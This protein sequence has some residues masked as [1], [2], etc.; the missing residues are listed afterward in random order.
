[1]KKALRGLSGIQLFEIIKN[2]ETEYEV[3]A[4]S[5]RL[6]YAQTMTRDVQ[7][8]SDP[9]YADDEI[10][11]D[12]EVLEGEDMELTIPEVALDLLPIVEGGTYDAN[13]KEYSFG[14]N[15]G[16]NYAMTFKSKMKNGCY[17]MFRYYNVKFKK[18]K[19]DLQTLD[20]GTQIASVVITLTAYRRALIETGEAFPK[21]R[22][23]KDTTLETQ[24]KDLK[25]LN[26]VPKVS[27]V[28]TTP[29]DD[30]DGNGEG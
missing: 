23:L 4:T 20:N 3:E 26:T 5:V 30:D 2:T 27:P 6:P 22:T 14:G 21:L 24:E 19:Q 29:T 15:N 7:S 1:M 28:E 11:D 9:V 17:R 18:A 8:S 16:K 13:T 12:E 25:W 10:Y